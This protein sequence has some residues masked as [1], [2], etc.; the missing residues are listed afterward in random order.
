METEATEKSFVEEP[1]DP[2][3]VS[4]EGASDSQNLPDETDSKKD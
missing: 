4:E 1:T 3:K 2:T